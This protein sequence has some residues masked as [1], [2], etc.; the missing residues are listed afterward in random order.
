[1]PPPLPASAVFLGLAN[2]KLNQ[3]EASEEAYLA[4]TRIKEN[5]RIAWQGLISLYE[6]QGGLKLDAYH[7]AVLKLGKIFAD[8]YGMKISRIALEIKL[9]LILSFS[10]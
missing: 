2:D 1:M 6:K 10:Q 5:D 7:D 3:N 9:I 4:A 8:R